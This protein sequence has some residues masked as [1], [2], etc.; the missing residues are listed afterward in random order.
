MFC[1]CIFSY[2]SKII[3]TFCLNGSL[4]TMILFCELIL[5]SF[6]CYCFQTMGLDNFNLGKFMS[7]SSEEWGI[8]L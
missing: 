4:I 2:L 1:L 6:Y 7:A 8:S 5:F 3:A